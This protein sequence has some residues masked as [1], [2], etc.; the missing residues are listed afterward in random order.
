[1]ALSAALFPFLGCMQASL[2]C[3]G[4]EIKKAPH[5]GLSLG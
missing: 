1:V 2:R 4:M 5:A 3:P